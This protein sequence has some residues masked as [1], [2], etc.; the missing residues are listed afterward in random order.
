MTLNGAS[1]VWRFRSNPGPLAHW[2]DAELTP[3]GRPRRLPIEAW[4]PC[5][6]L[7]RRTQADG[8][9]GWPET[10][11]ARLDGLFRW[12]VHFSRPD[13]SAVFG[14]RGD[15][16]GVARLIAAASLGADP[17]YASVVARWTAATVL[18]GRDNA[19][20]PLPSIR[21]EGQPMAMLRPDWSITGDWIAVDSR[22]GTEV[23][24][25]GEGRPWLSG[26][27]PI[28]DGSESSPKPTA[29]STGA[30]ADA[31]EWSS[32]WGSTKITRTAVLLRYRRVALLAQQEDGPATPG[33][34]VALSPGTTT[35]PTPG[36]R[37]WTLTRS[38]KTARLIAPG[39]PSLPYPTDRG[40]FGVVDGEAILTGAKENRR[41]WLPMVVTW[42]RTPIH[43]R[44]LTV[45]ERSQTCSADVAFGA[46]LAWG[47]GEEG[48]LIYRSLA[49]PALRVVLGHQT[50]A[51]FLIGR[52][53]REGNV[54]P[55]L[56]LD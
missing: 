48:L 13:G 27:W 17:G 56:S 53:T 37:S 28:A 41:R 32:R 22:S 40:T 19:P 6:D 42:G 45:T 46:R 24:V 33:L 29:W 7:L 15:K 4:G 11:A 21:A 12:L 51:R 34:R 47:S 1:D 35:A 2:L 25:A 31:F 20:P 9:E 23:E 26:L 10:F 18:A 38:R 43:W 30:Y 55:L 39:L 44:A 16:A 36:L 49:K 14:D 54:V 8:P 50:R 52:F 5:L 3:D